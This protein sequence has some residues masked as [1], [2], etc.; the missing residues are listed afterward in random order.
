M[1]DYK[2]YKKFFVVAAIWNWV[3]AIAF[4]CWYKQILSL[5]DMKPLI[6]PV[7][8]QLLSALVFVFG[9]G[10]YWVAGDIEK[11]QAIVKMGIIGKI[12]VFILLL[13]HWILGNIPF[14]LVGPGIVDLI[15]AILFIE[16]LLRFPKL[17]G[18]GNHH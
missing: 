11:N 15:F 16:F 10:Y 8:M 6:Y 18:T 1:R 9:I 12:L 2:Y 13:V 17:K 5:F 4:F 3:A 7:I 14:F